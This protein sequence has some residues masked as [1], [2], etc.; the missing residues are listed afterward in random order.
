MLLLTLIL[1]IIIA[2]SR[3]SEWYL[4]YKDIC[5]NNSCLVI[6]KLLD[7]DAT[8]KTEAIASYYNI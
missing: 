1:E 3:L 2:E 7:K 6:R 5:T 8:S 4:R